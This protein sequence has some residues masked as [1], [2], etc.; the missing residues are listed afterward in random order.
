[1][2]MNR[3]FNTHV[4]DL[5]AM[6]VGP[7]DQGSNDFECRKFTATTTNAANAI[8]SDWHGQFVEIYVTGGVLHYGFSTSS[9]AEIDRS[10]AASAAGASAKVGRIIPDGETR[11]ILI[12]LASAGDTIYFV[13]E[14][15]ASLT[16]LMSR[17]S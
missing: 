10:V 8:P 6:A 5:A 2:T 1:M 4:K 7:I 12:P 11:H 15:T 17:A 13:R 16:V 9:S 14:G 3:K